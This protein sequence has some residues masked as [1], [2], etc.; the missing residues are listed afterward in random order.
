MKTVA[1]I[2]LS[3]TEKQDSMRRVSRVYSLSPFRIH[4]RPWTVQNHVR[5]LLP[6]N[7]QDIH[8]FLSFSCTSSMQQSRSC[9]IVTFQ[10]FCVNTGWMALASRL[11]FCSQCR[12]VLVCKKH[13]EILWKTT[14]TC[15]T[16]ILLSM[17]THRFQT[18]CPKRL[19]SSRKAAWQGRCTWRSISTEMCRL[20]FPENDP[21]HPETH[22]KINDKISVKMWC[23]KVTSCHKISGASI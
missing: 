11:L 9:S 8:C 5:V 23:P 13:S 7:L 19:V 2:I 22:N 10:R 14:R 20:F 15:T 12:E 18:A 6:Q 16:Q 3:C 21:K 4:E 17:Y 1:E